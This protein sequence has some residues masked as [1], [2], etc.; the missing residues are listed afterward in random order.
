[1][2]GGKDMLSPRFS[3]YEGRPIFVNVAHAGVSGKSF[4]HVGRPLRFQRGR[5][6]LERGE[7]GL[8]QRVFH[9]FLP[10]P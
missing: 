10:R 6:F 1:M 7:S 5:L 9:S 4:R 3:L 8:T 2:R